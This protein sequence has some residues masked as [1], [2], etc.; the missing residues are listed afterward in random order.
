MY[1]SRNVFLDN[2]DLYTV[3]REH[4]RHLGGLSYPRRLQRLLQEAR[5]RR[6]RQLQLHHRRRRDRAGLVYYGRFQFRQLNE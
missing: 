4:H 2:R 1:I 3:H 5:P 6:V